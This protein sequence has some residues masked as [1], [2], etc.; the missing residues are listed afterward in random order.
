MLIIAKL[1]ASNCGHSETL[2]K[3]TDKNEGEGSSHCHDPKASRAHCT[4]HDTDHSLANTDLAPQG[5]R[6]HHQKV[7]DT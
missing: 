3:L 4:R 1:K 2:N 7:A 5:H 6:Q